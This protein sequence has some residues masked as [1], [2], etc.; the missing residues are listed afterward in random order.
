MRAPGK[1]ETMRLPIRMISIA[2]T[3]FWIFLI[4]FLVSAVYSVKDVRFDFGEPQMGLTSDNK[5]LF[6]LPITIDNR[7]Y[8][9][10]GCFNVTTEI[11]NR[12]G[13]MITRAS[14][15]IPVIKKDR[16]VMATHNVTINV[17]DLLQNSQDY[18]F[19]DTEL[20]V[21]E[22]V[23]L[24]L[25]EVIPVQ[26]STNL[27]MP[28]GAPLFN[29]TLGEIGYAGFSGTNMTA[30][31]PISF[32]NHASFDL[33]GNIQMCMYDSTDTLVSEGQTTI[34]APQNTQYYGQIELE[35]PM[36]GIT[37]NRYFEVYF[38]TPFFEFGPLVIP[39]D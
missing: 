26:A 33:A 13:F 2:T 29:F 32:E 27:S 7:G 34:E 5:M 36:A 9:N 31:V 3:F 35:V 11:L 4:A 15:F 17:N 24:K 28:W 39:Y 10:I 37:G 25:A 19:N 30:T 20:E 22:M 16:Q 8:Y 18:L 23:G 38:L 1:G 6:S 21:R 12:E 14:T